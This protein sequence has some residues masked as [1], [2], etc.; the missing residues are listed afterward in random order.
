MCRI[1]FQLA[2]LACGAHGRRLQL[3][4]ESF[5][6]DSH[7]LDV[8]LGPLSE[9]KQP[10]PNITVKSFAVLL[11]SLCQPKAGWQVTGHGYH[12]AQNHLKI[13]SSANCCKHAGFHD[14][15]V[16]S[17]PDRYITPMLPRRSSPPIAIA[18]ATLLASGTTAWAI[19]TLLLRIALGRRFQVM[20]AIAETR[21]EGNKT[22]ANELASH[23]APSIQRLIQGAPSGSQQTLAE[24]LA[25]RKP[26]AFVG[27]SPA[28]QLAWQRAVQLTGGSASLVPTGLMRNYS[29]AYRNYVNSEELSAM[30]NRRG[31]LTNLLFRLAGYTSLSIKK[32]KICSLTDKFYI[33][34]IIPIKIRWDGALNTGGDVI[35]WT[36]SQL[37]LGWR[38]LGKTIDKPSVTERLRKNPWLVRSVECGGTNPLALVLERQGIGRVVFVED[39][40]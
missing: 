23:V 11:F 12:L 20:R 16:V 17:C 22:L 30:M 1:V 6:G 32:D 33:F 34:G 10:R 14:A 31:A 25:L 21:P 2:C 26:G 24:L 7:L 9:V 3:T 35:N 40:Q 18:P 15:L 19:Y 5:R 28:E 27:E 29:F 37:R 38:W 39:V 13:G 8:K 36:T 4:F